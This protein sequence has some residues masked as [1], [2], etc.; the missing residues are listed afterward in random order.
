M[1]A[2]AI[3]VGH[4]SPMHALSSN[5]FTKSLHTLGQIL[6]PPKAILCISA[7]W[8][9]QGT[10]ITQMENPATIHDFGGFPDALFEIEYPAKGSPEVAD[11]VRT[12]IKVPEGASRTLFH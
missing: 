6:P 2:P 11:L 1:K 4:G 9:T 8:T 3:F 7:H 10:W 5:A 12:K